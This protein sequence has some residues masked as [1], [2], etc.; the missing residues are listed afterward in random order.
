MSWKNETQDTFHL[1]LISKNI[2]CCLLHKFLETSSFY[3]AFA[4]FESW[5][6]V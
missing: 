1:S 6:D 3:H 2:C 5:S 4:S